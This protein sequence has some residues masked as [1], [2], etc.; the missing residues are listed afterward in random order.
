MDAVRLIEEAYEAKKYSYAPYSGFHVGAALLT[1]DGRIFRGCNIENRQQFFERNDLILLF[2]FGKYHPKRVNV[3]KF[4]HNLSAYAAGGK[5]F[6][7]VSCYGDCRKPKSPFRY[8]FKKCRTLRTVCGRIRSIF[9]V[10]A[11]E[12]SSVFRKQRRP[13][14]KPGT[15][16]IQTRVSDRYAQRT[17]AAGIFRERSARVRQKIQKIKIS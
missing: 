14:M 8:R 5:I 11:P 10:A 6:F 7:M 3:A 2:G 17:A 15:C 12:Y 9:N 1:E 16:Q 13:D 4:C